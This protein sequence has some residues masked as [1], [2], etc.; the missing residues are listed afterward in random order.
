MSASGHVD[1]FSQARIV[2]LK[3]LP[4]SNKIW[5]FL[6]N[7]RTRCYHSDCCLSGILHLM[8][9]LRFAKSKCRTLRGMKGTTPLKMIPILL[10]H[11]LLFH[12]LLFESFFRFLKLLPIVEFISVHYVSEEYVCFEFSFDFCVAEKITLNELDVVEC[13]AQSIV[14]GFFNIKNPC[15]LNICPVSAL[16]VCSST[17]SRTHQS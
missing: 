5:N 6:G 8:G 17:Q 14:F 11:F 15:A 13:E 3:N 16:L 4:F 1:T 2:H 10:L 9:L 12:F 7:S